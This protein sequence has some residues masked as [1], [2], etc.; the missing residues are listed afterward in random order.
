[1]EEKR[2]KTGIMGGTFNPIHYG[3]L[4]IAENAAE[5]FGLDEILFIPT[6]RSPHKSDRQ[7]LDA[8][9]RCDMIRLAISDNAAFRLSTI[10]IEADEVNYTY[11]TVDHLRDQSPDRELYFI[12]GGDS[13]QAFGT[14][15]YPEHIL[16]EAGLLVAVRDDVDE[17]ELKEQIQS[18]E[19]RYP[20]A[21]IACLKTPNY[22]LSSHRIRALAAKGRTIRYMVPEAV[23]CYIEEHHLYDTNI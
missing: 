18:L 1:M 13:L 14:W 3:H 15:R 21:R 17:A 8:A 7:I 5:Q 23:R 19:Q 11:R 6:G 4:L 10:E 12:M 20:Q 16:D 9:L 22:S 2:I